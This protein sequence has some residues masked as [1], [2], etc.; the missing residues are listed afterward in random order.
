MLITD[1]FNNKKLK[2]CYIIKLSVYL[3]FYYSY[4]NYQ[5]FFRYQE[6]RSKQRSR[7]ILF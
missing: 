3:Y 1:Y 2:N 5:N 6:I 4:V 7:N